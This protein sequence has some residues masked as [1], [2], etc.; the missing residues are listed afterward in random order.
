MPAFNYSVKYQYIYCDRNSTFVKIKCNPF[1]K[2][3]LT[4]QQ[5]DYVLVVA[6]VSFRD[7]KPI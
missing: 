7:E 3:Q 1:R 4:I 2:F 6:L 5:S